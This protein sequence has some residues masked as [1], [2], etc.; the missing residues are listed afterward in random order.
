M[1]DK[2]KNH[3]TV[4]KM[5]WDFTYRGRRRQGEKMVAVEK[6]RNV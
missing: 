6:V 3:S 5:V 1:G 4:L 2:K